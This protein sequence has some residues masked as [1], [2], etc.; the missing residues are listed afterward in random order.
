MVF[1]SRPRTLKAQPKIWIYNSCLE[2]PIFVN[3]IIDG[4]FKETLFKCAL[5]KVMISKRQKDFKDSFNKLWWKHLRF[6]PL[7]FWFDLIH[8]YW[9]L[10]V[11]N[12]DTH[13]NTSPTRQLNFVF[14]DLYLHTKAFYSKKNSISLTTR[15]FAQVASELNHTHAHTHAENFTLSFSSASFEYTLYIIVFFLVYVSR[16]SGWI[17]SGSNNRIVVIQVDDFKGNVEMWWR[18][19]NI[20]GKTNWKNG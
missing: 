4:Q 8:Y 13:T 15:P 16:N 1:L 3:I 7:W 11:L 12:T 5:E 9:V 10:W 6:S 18:G 14:M 17:L 2:W 20:S 19:T